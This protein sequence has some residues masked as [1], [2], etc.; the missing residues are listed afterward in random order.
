MVIKYRVGIQWGIAMCHGQV[1]HSSASVGHPIDGVSIKIL[2]VVQ[3]KIAKPLMSVKMSNKSKLNS[4]V[5][6]TGASSEGLLLSM[7]G[8]VIMKLLLRGG[9]Q[10]EN[11]LKKRTE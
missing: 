7:M 4:S 1:K 2:V 5:N 9:Q 3:H 11:G 8:L 10:E 6:E